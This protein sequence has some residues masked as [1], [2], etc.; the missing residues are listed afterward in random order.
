MHAKSFQS[1]LTFCNPI[2]CS[3][4]S[5]LSTG[6]CRQEYWSGL[7]WLPSR[8]L[9]IPGIKPTSLTSPA[10]AGG[11]FLFLFCFVFVFTTRVT[12]E[13]QKTKVKRWSKKEIYS[14]W[15]IKCQSSGLTCKTR[16]ENLA[17]TQCQSMG[18]P[19][20]WYKFRIKDSFQALGDIL[21][22][23]SSFMED[24]GPGYR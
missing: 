4:Q 18:A 8:D 15:S 3:L 7:S 11:C 22:C 5:P 13:A 1:C 10:L 21:M 12:W 16:V 14:W 23:P 24:N 20:L 9:P 17:L 19:V 6:F 2:D